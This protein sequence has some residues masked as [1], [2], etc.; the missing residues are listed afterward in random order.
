MID[1]DSISTLNPELLDEMAETLKVMA[2]P[3]RIAILGL[4]ENGDS[5][6]VTQIQEYLGIGQSHTSH[7]LK[8]MKGRGVVNIT[9]TGKLH[10]YSLNKEALS[11][12]LCCFKRCTEK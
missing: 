12:V 11:N 8:L 2:H 7:H 6:T 4:L 9:R 1:R 3:M 10:F 5:F